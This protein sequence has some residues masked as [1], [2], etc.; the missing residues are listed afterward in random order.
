MQQPSKDIEFQRCRFAS[1]RM[2]KC[3]RKTFILRFAAAIQQS[4]GKRASSFN[5]RGIIHEHQCGHGRIRCRSLSRAFFATRSVE[6]LQHGM[7]KLALP[8]NVNPASPLPCIVILFV[9]TFRKVEMSIVALG[10]IRLYARA[11]D[12]LD[13]Q[14]ADRQ[15]V[16]ANHLRRQSKRRL[17]CI[18]S[19]VRINVEQLRPKGCPNQGK[20][21]SGIASSRSNPN[22]S[23]YKL[24]FA[25]P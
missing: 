23:S 11:T 18:E 16:V 19:V 15:R 7:Q 25:V 5:K 14:A 3:P 12:V 20:E 10:L 6:G 17:T 21:R 8:V 4:C 9:C 1:H 2:V 24:A 22:G 13:Q